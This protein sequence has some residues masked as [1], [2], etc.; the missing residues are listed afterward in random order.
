MSCPAR[1]GEVKFEY[2]ANAKI[3]TGPIRDPMASSSQMRHPS[4]RLM[5]STIGSEM[6]Q[7]GIAKKDEKYMKLTNAL[8]RVPL[9]LLKHGTKPTTK[10][11]EMAQT[12]DNITR[13]SFVMKRHYLYK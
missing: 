13:D 9:E 12:K 7:P 10:S 5:L 3:T 8:N 1:F 2:K 11:D 6:S 4:K